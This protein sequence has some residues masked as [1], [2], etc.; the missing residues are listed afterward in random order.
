VIIQRIDLHLEVRIV[1]KQSGIA[2]AGT[3]QLFAHIHDLVLL[4]SD[5]GLKVLDGGGKLN[6][7]RRLCIDALLKVRILMSVLFLQRLKVIEF[8]LEAHHLVLE[9]DDLT[10]AIDKLCFLIL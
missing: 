2:V 1:V 9:L 7:S 4:G 8:V 3:L 6:V 10:L 5:L